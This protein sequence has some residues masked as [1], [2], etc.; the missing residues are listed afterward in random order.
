MQPLSP[1]QTPPVVPVEYAG[2]WIAWSRDGTR[3]V[4]SGTTLDEAVQA[5]AN[6]GEQEPVFAKVPK[7]DVRFVGGRG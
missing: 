2:R 3:I 6:A 4:A 1:P 5:A 7:A